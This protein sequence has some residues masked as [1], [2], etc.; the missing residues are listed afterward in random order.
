MAET[1]RNAGDADASLRALDALRDH[2]E[3][4]SQKLS[5]LKRNVSTNPVQQAGYSSGDVELF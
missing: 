1:L 4:L 5:D 2:V 3:T